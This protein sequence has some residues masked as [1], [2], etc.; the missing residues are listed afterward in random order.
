[1]KF[2]FDFFPILLFFVTYKFGPA[3]VPEDQ[4]WLKEKPIYLAT[5]VAMVASVVQV[6]YTWLKTRKVETMHVVSLVLIIVFGGATLYL[7]D[8]LFIKWKPTVLNWLF[9]A[10][11]LGSQFI[12]DRPVIQRMLSAQVDLPEPVWKRLN[13]TWTFFFFV[14]GAINLAVAYNFDEETWVNFKLFG[15]LGLTFLFVILQSLYLARYLPDSKPE[16]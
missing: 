6:A 8:P 3:F 13:L 9:G 10:V 2:L 16:N 4:I 11:F 14:V 5:L 15:M 7:K 1:M 12:G